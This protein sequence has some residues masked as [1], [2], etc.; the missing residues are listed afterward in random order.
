VSVTG[1]VAALKAEARTLGPL[2]NGQLLAIS[3]M[4]AQAAARAAEALVAAG[5]QGLLSFGLAG[6][7]D[8]QL[9]AGA[10]VLAHRV[11]DGAGGVHT[12]Y[13]PWRERLAA[14]AASLSEACGV[15]G[16]GLLSVAQPLTT[17]EAK[18]QARASSG[19]A[20]V[21]MESFAIAEV[22]AR[23]GVKFAVARVVIDRA[24]DALPR[25]VIRATGAFGDVSLARL[26]AGLVGAPADLPALLRLPQ[27]YR[28]ALR[29]LRAL[30]QLDLG[31]P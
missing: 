3:G 27:R 15:V 16:G 25:S 19:A 30:G 18:S 24:A 10:L 4:G 5:A 23:M 31:V 2:P 21:D 11:V 9:G 20:A 14:Q 6:A 7:L 26:V 28:A 29:A 22:A 13:G 17:V 8:P 12:T 1:I